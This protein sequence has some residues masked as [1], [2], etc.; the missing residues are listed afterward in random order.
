MAKSIYYRE[1][2]TK[3]GLFCL[4][5]LTKKLISQLLFPVKKKC[6]HNFVRLKEEKNLSQILPVNTYINVFQMNKEVWGKS[7]AFNRTYK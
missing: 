1:A 5:G 3:D 2:Y 7:S 6:Q 4:I